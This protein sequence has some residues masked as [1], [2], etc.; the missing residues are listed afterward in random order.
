M[1]RSLFGKKK[2]KLS[3]LYNIRWKKQPIVAAFRKCPLRA[4]STKRFWWLP[5]WHVSNPKNLCEIARKKTSFWGG[6]TFSPFACAQRTELWEFC[7]LTGSYRP[8][9]T[10]KIDQCQ[11][12]EE[13]NFK[14]MKETELWTFWNERFPFKF[15]RIRSNLASQRW[16]NVHSWFIWSKSI[17]SFPHSRDKEELLN[18][19][20][21]KHFAGNKLQ[22][23][24]IEDFIPKSMMVLFSDL[25]LSSWQTSICRMKKRKQQG[26]LNWKC[27]KQRLAKLFFRF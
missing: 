13:E 11:W 18:Y 3:F 15:K 4:Q 9:F 12:K 5:D 24:H 16:T 6:R 20:E 7:S 22:S 17:L 10:L 21:M 1:T 14:A 19:S 2:F 8:N 23:I 25:P 26:F 27:F